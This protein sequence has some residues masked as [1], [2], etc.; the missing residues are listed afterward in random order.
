MDWSMCGVGVGTHNCVR[1][2]VRSSLAGRVII[3]RIIGG[4]I[5]GGRIIGGRKYAS[6]RF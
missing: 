4:R 1:S 6:L 5:I 3:G 2:C